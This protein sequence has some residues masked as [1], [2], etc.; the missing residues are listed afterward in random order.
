MIKSFVSLTP[1]Y[2]ITIS[3]DIYFT[4]YWGTIRNYYKVFL[5]EDQVFNSN[6]IQTIDFRA[7]STYCASNAIL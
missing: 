1:H 6:D 5:D 4:E 7:P 3:V 2:S